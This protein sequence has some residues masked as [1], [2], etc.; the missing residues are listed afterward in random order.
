MT[1]YLL[2]APKSDLERWR[3]SARRHGLSLAA[4]IRVVLESAERAELR[5]VTPDPLDT[6]E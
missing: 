3:R 2:R 4:W 6:D 5:V 1:S